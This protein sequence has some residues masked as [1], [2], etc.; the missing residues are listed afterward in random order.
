MSPRTY[1]LYDLLSQITSL[2]EVDRLHLLRLLRD[3]RIPE[4]D[5]EARPVVFQP[6]D[7]ERL[8]DIYKRD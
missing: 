1:A 7:I 6:Y 3:P 2:C 8:E 5:A 4:I